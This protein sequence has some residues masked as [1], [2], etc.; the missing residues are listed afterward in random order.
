MAGTST[1]RAECPASSAGRT[2]TG[3]LSIRACSHR[4]RPPV[5]GSGRCPTCLLDEPRRPHSRPRQP[6][7]LLAGPGLHHR[8]SHLRFRRGGR[9]AA[10]PDHH[11]R[12]LL[13]RRADV[14]GV[15]HLHGNRDRHRR[16]ERTNRHGRVQ[17]HRPGPVRLAGEL[18][19][20]RRGRRS[21]G[22]SAEVHPEP[23]RRGHDHRCVL[24]RCHAR[25]EQRGSLL[26][27]LAPPSSFVPPLAKPSN[28]FSLSRAKLNR[29]MAARP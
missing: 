9:C 13:A 17:L 10:L 28:S 19:S 12:G 4:G 24:G 21:V 16:P 7:R 1:G 6:R 23:R 3:A 22:L 5:R 25:G 8:R 18:L 26:T 2:W 14:A 27:V 20:S 29:E 11:E 15:D